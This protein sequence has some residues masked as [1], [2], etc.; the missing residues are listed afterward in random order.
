M[1]FVFYCNERLNCILYLIYN[2]EI[3]ST[4]DS[5]MAS[6]MAAKMEI[7]FIGDILQVFF[8]KKL[9]HFCYYAFGHHLECIML[10]NCS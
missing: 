8:S 7:L 5:S 4:V 1:K 3:F 6:K 9:S 10:M 2:I